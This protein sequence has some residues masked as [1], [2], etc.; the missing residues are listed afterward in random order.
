MIS[1]KPGSSFERGCHECTELLLVDGQPGFAFYHT[2]EIP[3]SVHLL[4]HPSVMIR[5]PLLVREPLFSA[6]N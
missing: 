5:L 4:L 1:W 2:S 3:G 6:L